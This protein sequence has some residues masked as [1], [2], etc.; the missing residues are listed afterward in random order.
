MLSFIFQVLPE[1]LLL[2]QEDFF[3]FVLSQRRLGF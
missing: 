1:G 2:Q 3:Y